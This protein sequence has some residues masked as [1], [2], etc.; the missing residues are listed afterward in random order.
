MTHP[1][2][3]S[4]RESQPPNHDP[5]HINFGVCYC[6]CPTCTSPGR[7]TPRCWWCSD[8]ERCGLHQE[9]G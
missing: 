2:K 5:H 9:A 1:D 3:A 4:D 8:R 7:C 6:D